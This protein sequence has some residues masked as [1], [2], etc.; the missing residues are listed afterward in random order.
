MAI[1]RNQGYLGVMV[2]DLTQKGVDPSGAVYRMFTSR[3][4]YRLSL[5]QDNADLRLTVYASKKCPGLISEKRLKFNEEIINGF[6]EGIKFLKT[7]YVGTHD[8][9]QRGLLGDWGV[10]L[11][12]KH[13]WSYF[14]VLEQYFKN[15]QTNSKNLRRKNQSIFVDS[16]TPNGNRIE[17][18]WFDLLDK[19][20]GL[21]VP[22]SSR[23]LPDVFVRKD[24]VGLRV[25]Q[26][27]M[28][29]C[30]YENVLRKQN[31]EIKQLEELGGIKIPDDFEYEMIGIRNEEIDILRQVRPKKL[32]DIVG[33]RDVNPSSVLLV[34]KAVQKFEKE[35]NNKT[36]K[37]TNV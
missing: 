1:G 8:A 22:D 9:Y 28:V 16:A 4:E 33:L 18:E 14:K 7:N 13:R 31:E 21:L 17:D 23:N 15:L 19:N 6:S 11:P 32:S 3:S 5:R 36:N 27:L 2:S 30:M 34:M 26:K 20:W 12:K 37:L 29:H 35:K 24:A 10:K 25:R